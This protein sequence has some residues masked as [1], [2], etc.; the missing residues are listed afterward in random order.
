MK[1]ILAVSALALSLFFLPAAQAEETLTQFS[2]SVVENDSG[3]SETNKIYVAN[4]MTRYDI[5]NGKEII[6][7]RYDKKLTWIIFPD[8]KRYV[9]EES[10]EFQ[11]A[12]PPEPKEGTLG[13]MTR[14]FIG[15]EEADSYRLKKFLVSV[16]LPRPNTKKDKNA[17]DTE[18][19]SFEYYEWYRSGFPF[20]VK[21]ASVQGESTSEFTKLKIG[22]Q[23]PE[24]FTKPQN[25]K[26][27]TIEEIKSLESGKKK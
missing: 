5:K 2:A 24:L 26:P 8:Y 15:F 23:N 11:P 16:K 7:T 22:P 19:Y 17:K 6:I 1:R 27:A 14:K 9:E 20:P 3:K 10:P 4:G 18:Q 25:Y 21:T 12:D 13:N